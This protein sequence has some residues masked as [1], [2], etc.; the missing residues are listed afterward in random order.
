MLDK[1]MKMQT[2]LY[3][4]IKHTHFP[5]QL[6]ACKSEDKPST[7]VLLAQVHMIIKRSYISNMCPE[8]K[9][10]CSYIWANVISGSGG[11]DP[12]KLKC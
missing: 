3:Q 8:E 10:Q 12:E 9:T 6:L 4:I 1:D 11:G 5:K 2:C 7:V